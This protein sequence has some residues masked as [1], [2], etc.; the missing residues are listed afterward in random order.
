MELSQKIMQVYP[1]VTDKD[2]DYLAGGTILLRDDGD[3]LG[4]YIA[5]WD[6]SKP[7]PEGMKVGK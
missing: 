6:Y 3:G 5:Q 4:A 2:F 7:I 1:E